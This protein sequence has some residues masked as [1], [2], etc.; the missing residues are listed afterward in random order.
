MAAPHVAGVVALLWSARPTLVRNIAETKA[1][2]YKSSANPAV[3]V[4]PVENCGGRSSSQ[5]PNNSF[6]YGHVVPPPTGARSST[7]PPSTRCSSPRATTCTPASPRPHCSAGKSVF[8]E[9]PMARRAAELDELMDAWRTAAASF[10]SASTVASRQP[11]APEGRLRGTPPAAGDGLSRRTPAASPPSS[12]VVDPSRAAAASVGEVCHM[13]DTLVDLAG[14]PV[15]SVYRPALAGSADDVVLSLGVRRRLDR[16]HRLR[17]RRRPGMPK[18]YL[19]VLGGAPL[20]RPGRLSDTA[21]LRQR[22]GASVGGRLAAPGQRPR[23]RAGRVRRV[24]PSRRRV[25]VRPRGRRPRHT[26]NLRRR[27][28]RA[29]GPARRG[30][31]RCPTPA[32]RPHPTPRCVPTP[33]SSPRGTRTSRCAPLRRSSPPRE[34]RLSQIR[35]TSPPRG[36][37]HRTRLPSASP[38]IL[39][40]KDPSSQFRPTSPPPDVSHRTRL[41]SATPVILPGKDPSSQIRLTCPAPGVSPRTRLPSATPVVLP[42][43]DTS[44]QI[45]LTSPSPD[46]THHPRFHPAAR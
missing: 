3:T 26:R 28:I 15:V 38:V 8:L 45:R 16:H 29:H 21:A 5:I 11:S 41:P 35:P 34:T 30:R 12:W 31:S 20:G 6:G 33:S 10:R 44:L 14:A 42:G 1:N 18:E 36:V 24:R 39:P 4:S 40:G 13:L 22:L 27:R 43:K 2:L 7:I 9:K 37:S 17:Q 23:R 46:V 19:E 25:T 32:A